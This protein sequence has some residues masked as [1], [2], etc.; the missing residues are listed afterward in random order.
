MLEALALERAL[1]PKSEKWPKLYLSSLRKHRS[2][3]NHSEG[4]SKTADLTVWEP[5]M[6]C[7]KYAYS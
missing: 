6:V 4:V 3:T 5:R 2:H 1:I 7:D